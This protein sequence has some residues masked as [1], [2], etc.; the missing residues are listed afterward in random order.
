MLS[1][2]LLLLVLAAF[3]VLGT[4]F[5]G[6][7]FGRGEILEPMEDPAAV[8]DKNRSLI[9]EGRVDD[10]RFELTFRGYRPEHVDAVIDDLKTRLE[11]AEQYKFGH[12]DEKLD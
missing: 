7:I 2:I 1:W 11:L 12:Q 3:V 5:F 6:T 9:E 10:I 8:A 4:W